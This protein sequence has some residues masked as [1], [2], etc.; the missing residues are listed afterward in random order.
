MVSPSAGEH[1]LA[2]DVLEISV[3]PARMPLARASNS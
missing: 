2:Q 1:A 3:V